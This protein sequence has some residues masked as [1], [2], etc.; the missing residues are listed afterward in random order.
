G[1]IQG[2]IVE[3]ATD[4]PV[5]GVTVTVTSPN[6]GDPR[7]VTSNDN[8]EFLV[9]GLPIG[10]YKVTVSYSGVKPITRTIVVQPDTTSP[11]DI[12]WPA[13]LAE[14]ETTTVFEERPVTNPNSTQT[15]TVVSPDQ[16]KYISASNR[17]LTDPM[18]L[19]PGVTRGGTSFNLVKGGRSG[20]N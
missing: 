9:P 13:E 4:L 15:G 11:V 7:I 5:P 17:R 8:G 18:L 20:D 19:V 3:A 14:T 1:Q 16:M 10:T 2:R 6:L 12:K